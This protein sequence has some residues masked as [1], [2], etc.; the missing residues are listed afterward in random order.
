[1]KKAMSFYLPESEKIA[2]KEFANFNDLS[3]TDVIRLA[4]KSY[5]NRD[6]KPGICPICGSIK[7]E[8]NE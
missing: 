6:F 7:G 2:L 8:S 3:Y 4:L 5:I 1:M